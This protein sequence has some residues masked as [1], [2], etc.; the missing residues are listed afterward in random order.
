MCYDVVVLWLGFEINA[1]L[2]IMCS[3]VILL[4]QWSFLAFDNVCGLG[5]GCNAIF[6]NY[7]VCFSLASVY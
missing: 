1:F 5:N 4:L 2:L 6:F 7:K 3:P